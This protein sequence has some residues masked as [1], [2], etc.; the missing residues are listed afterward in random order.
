MSMSVENGTIAIP[1]EEL[2]GA[3]ARH[4][5][6]KLASLGFWVVAIYPKRWVIKT[7]TR[8]KRASGKE[9]IGTE[10]GRN[11]ATAAQLNELFAKF[12]GAGVGI[13][14]GP[15]RSP[16]GRWLI[17]VEGD[18]PQAEASR[19]KLLGA[20]PP[21]TA[22][23]TSSR[24]D[25]GLVIVHD[26]TRMLAI[27]AA[28]GRRGVIKDEKGE[29]NLPD[30]E[31]RCGGVNST[32]TAIQLQSVCPPTR[33]TDGAAREWAGFKTI[34]P[35][36]EQFYAYLEALAAEKAAKQAAVGTPDANGHSSA[37]DPSLD[38]GDIVELEDKRAWFLKKLHGLAE[39]VR[40]APE[41]VRH[42]TLRE[43]GRTLGGYLGNPVVAKYSLLNEAAVVAAL[44]AAGIK[45]GLDLDDVAATVA[46]GIGKGKEEPLPWPTALEP[47]G[48]CTVEFEVDEEPIEEEPVDD[49]PGGDGD[50]V[51]GGDDGGGGDPGGDGDDGGGDN[52]EPAAAPHAD[53][54]AG[55]GEPAAPPPKKKLRRLSMAT[56]AAAIAARDAALD[57][58][59]DHGEPESEPPPKKPGKA[60]A[61]L[62]RPVVEITPRRDIA[63][64]KTLE[65]LPQDQELFRRGDVLVTLAVETH[66]EIELTSQSTLRNTAGAPRVVPLSR[67]V[68]GCRL[69][70][71]C[72][73]KKRRLTKDKESGK[74]KLS[75][76]SAHPPNW[77][78]GAVATK[79][80]YPGVRPL[81]A[82]AEAPFLRSDG[83]I[84]ETPGYDDAS[85][86]YYV[87]GGVFPQVP[88][89]PTQSDAEEAAMR[90]LGFFLEFPFKNPPR[91]GAAVLAALLTLVARP[92]IEGPVPG[93]A[94]IGNVM[95]C[96]KGLLVDALAI[97]AT[98]RAAPTTTFP[99]GREESSKVV[100]SIALG[101]QPLTHFDNI[102][103]GRS[104]GNGP[105]DSALTSRFINDRILGV[106]RFTGEIAL[107]CVWFVSGN[108]ITPAG[109]APRRWVPIF[110]ASELERPFEREDIIVKDLRA[111]VRAN[112][113]AIV[114]DALTI[115]RAHAL[116]GYP[117]AGKA[118]LGSF[119]EWDK[120]V[121]GAVRFAIGTDPVTNLRGAADDAPDRQLKLALLAGWAELPAG[122][123]T[124][125]TVN[126]ALERL[127]EHPTLHPTLR[128]ALMGLSKDGNLPPAR[129]V[130]YFLRGMTGAT[131]G[132]RRFEKTG[133]NQH[134][135]LW[136]V[137]CD[138]PDPSNDPDDDEDT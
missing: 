52:P 115:L 23:W 122:T 43:N 3:D 93:T 71:L 91:D 69:T 132:G 109:D 2:A 1:I 58:D 138:V 50:G 73:F 51:G 102:E 33:G 89:A 128:D 134:Q 47:P 55:D 10:W 114:C 8:N 26:E 61:A 131:I 133:L 22:G 84:V 34:Q 110:L 95:G 74:G 118:P 112:R 37:W 31:I 39:N 25:H 88:N 35:V 67:D 6:L 68:L 46:Y 80:S 125:T 81:L 75:L 57:A 104:F 4:A 65:A 78:V 137:T 24:G 27:Q 70:S 20:E 59:A 129:T 64:A 113:G 15:G 86:T 42:N 41:G 124:G 32:G 94:V 30:L 136:K 120:I 119:E 54:G 85:G 98:G 13:C 9:P 17:D 14:L 53:A 45:S 66:N 126:A 72:D 135:S 49:D 87:P 11:R 60:A 97:A 130:G 116:A 79:N 36:P 16:D 123:T 111:H 28:L 83:T 107:R 77:L 76:G 101:A 108:N 90:I 103:E 92:A 44:R 106:S 105:L 40:N 121:R 21:A 127:K 99:T 96:G 117:A 82:L 29:S 5:A 19:S 12:P 56:V 62:A 38:I 100:T 18:G 48:V 7:K 63:L